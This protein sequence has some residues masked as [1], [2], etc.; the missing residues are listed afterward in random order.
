MYI[1]L[2][3]IIY[4]YI[5]FFPISR[6]I[7]ITNCSFTFRCTKINAFDTIQRPWYL[8]ILLFGVLCKGFMHVGDCMSELY[9]AKNTRTLSRNRIWI[10]L[11]VM[12][13]CSLDSGQWLYYIPSI[14]R[15]DINSSWVINLIHLEYFKVVEENNH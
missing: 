9:Y 11:R 6:F 10:F 1:T 8:V 12:F 5:S 13:F 3:M 4:S 7:W 14:E 2:M 15:N